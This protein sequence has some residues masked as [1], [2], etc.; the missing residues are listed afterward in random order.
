V[1]D[2]TKG[3][4]CDND[5]IRNP[6]STTRATKTYVHDA[7]SDHVLGN[8]SQ[9]P[10][11][12]RRKATNLVAGVGGGLGLGSARGLLRGGSHCDCVEVGVLGVS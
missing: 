9:V 4:T 1:C 11:K 2:A 8:V 10:A 7:I 6:T 3:A 12:T 5:K